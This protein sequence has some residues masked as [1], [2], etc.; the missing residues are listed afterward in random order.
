MWLKE[1]KKKSKDLIKKSLPGFSLIEIM[2]V[3]TLIGILMAFGTVYIMGQLE[4][5]RIKTARSQSYE[6]AKALDLYRLNFGSYP[7]TAEGLEALSK[8]PHGQP[9]MEKVP[10]D[11]WGR[12]FNYANPGVHNPR[13]VDVWSNGPS[14]KEGSDEDAIGNWESSEHIP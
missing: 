1:I 5:G 12:E 8:P 7:S 6:I 14:K 2:V 10:L 3:V 13:G 11:P 9:L 4:E